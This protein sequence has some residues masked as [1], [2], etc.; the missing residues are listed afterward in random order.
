MNSVTQTE[1]KIEK[2]KPYNV[3]EDIIPYT[4]RRYDR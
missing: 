4:K 2:I 1:R 3:T